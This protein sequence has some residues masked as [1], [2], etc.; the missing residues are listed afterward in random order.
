MLEHT[1][2]AL[3]WNII[4]NNLEKR[5]KKIFGQR[6]PAVYPMWYPTLYI[7]KLVMKK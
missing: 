2:P 6:S 3:L 5:E 7:A 4:I 1:F